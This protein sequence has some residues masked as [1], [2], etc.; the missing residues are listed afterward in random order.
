MTSPEPPVRWVA[1]GRITRA[2]GVRGEVSVLP[3]SDVEE[4]FAPPS[5]LF[6]GESQ[7]RPLT[8]AASR[9]NRDRL[10]VRFEEVPD[11]TGAEALTG[12][13]LFVPAA[14]SPPLPEGEFWPHQLI[15][16]EVLTDSGRSLGE[17][18][19]VVHTNANDVWVARGADGAESLVPALRDVIVSVDTDARRVVVREIPGLTAPDET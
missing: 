13:Y 1:V 17:L 8:V 5:R 3:L 6:V 9:P 7:D 4:R 11:R 16:S 10:L 12:A 2:H 18:R 19:E 14:S 15:G